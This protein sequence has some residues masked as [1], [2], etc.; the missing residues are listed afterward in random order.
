MLLAVLGSLGRNRPNPPLQIK[1]GGNGGR[2]DAA[3][4][5]GD[6]G[7]STSVSARC[8]VRAGGTWRLGGACCVVAPRG[9]S[10][11]GDHSRL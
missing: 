4:R 3:R 5:C 10:G 1:T 8:A 7:A 11:A 2:Q 6:P 9:R